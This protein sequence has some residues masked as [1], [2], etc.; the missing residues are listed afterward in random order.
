MS[1]SEGEEEL[2]PVPNEDIQKESERERDSSLLE[3][4][5]RAFSFLLR[6]FCSSLPLSFYSLINQ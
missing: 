1:K 6:R 2:S 3:I 5:L 4:F